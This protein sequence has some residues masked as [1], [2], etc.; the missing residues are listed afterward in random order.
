MMAAEDDDPSALDGNAAA[1]LLQE[2]FA[3]EATSAVLNCDGCGAAGPI[4]AARLYGGA[5]GWVLRCRHCD[6]VMLR[7]A[8][9]PQGLWV[10]MRGA[11]VLRAGA[12]A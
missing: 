12:A 4:G 5:M 11:R 1:A 8:R 2:V 6:G 7:L 3:F 10:D 9:T